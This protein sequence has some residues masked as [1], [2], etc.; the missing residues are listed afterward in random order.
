MGFDVDYVKNVRRKLFVCVNEIETIVCVFSLCYKN[1]V[2]SIFVKK[3]IR[4]GEIN[5][6]RSDYGKG[7]FE[8]MKLLYH[9]EKSDSLKKIGKELSSLIQE[10]IDADANRK[11]N[12]TITI[13]LEIVNNSDMMELANTL[14]PK[15]VLPYV[16]KV[17][18]G[19]EVYKN[20]NQS[21]YLPKD[22]ADKFKM[23]I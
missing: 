17:T 19:K 20:P 7:L 23:S 21:N 16:S 13:S 15:Y 10:A 9:V 12:L 4:K 18:V 1:N 14:I 22:L 8:T 11:R 6:S 3:Y 2:I 5:M